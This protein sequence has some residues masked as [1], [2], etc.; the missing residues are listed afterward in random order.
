MSKVFNYAMLSVGLLLLF[1]YSGLPTGID[2]IL[3]YL[4]IGSNASGITLSTWW[5]LIAGIFTVGSGAG[6]VISFFTRTS[7]ESYLVAPF[8]TAVFW[9]V[10]MTFISIVNYTQAIGGV[11]YYIVYLIL[12][13]LL[14]S[15]GI[16]LIPF[17]RGSGG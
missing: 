15:F 13:P 6:I 1:K 8:A 12:I 2:L 11:Y 14:V 10:G 4:N 16:A 9:L 5:L 7:P 17:W 3:S